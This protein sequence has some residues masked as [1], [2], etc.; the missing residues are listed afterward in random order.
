M[1][2]KAKSGLENLLLR[3]AGELREL[4]AELKKLQKPL[5]QQDPKNPEEPREIGKAVMVEPDGEE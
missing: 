5:V 2:I 4:R 3:K 1:A